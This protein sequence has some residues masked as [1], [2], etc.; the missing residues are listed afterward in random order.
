MDKREFWATKSPLPE[1]HAVVFS[2]PSFDAPIRLVANQFAEV[3]L[4][5]FVHTPA[6]MS[7]APPKKLG[8]QQAKLTMSFP[9][10][11]VGRSFK[12]MIA[13]VASVRSRSPITVSYSVYLDDL[14]SPAVTW[15]LY[16]SDDAGVAFGE[17]VVQVSATDTNPMRRQVS[18]IYDPS[19]FTGL[20]FL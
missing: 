12:K 7:I 13:K 20:E 5:G 11:V 1:Y 14:L 17:E 9:R 15:S 8:G 6:P 3:T 16:I 18:P 4:G 2:H 10:A 19:I